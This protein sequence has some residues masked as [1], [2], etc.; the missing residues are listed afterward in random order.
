MGKFIF[1]F[2]IKKILFGLGIIF[3]F[4]FIFAVVS[5]AT[6]ESGFPPTSP[7]FEIKTSTLIL[8]VGDIK[9][10]REKIIKFVEE[11]GGL[12]VQSTI[13]QTENTSYGTFIL[14][15]PAEN[16]EETTVYFKELGERVTYERTESRDVR[17]EYSDLE[18]RLKNLEEEESELLKLMEREGTISEAL[19][20][21][22][23]LT[24]IRDEIEKIQEQ[25]QCLE[26]EAKMATVNLN[27]GISEKPLPEGW[28]QMD[29]LTNSLE[30]ISTFLR[31]LGYFVI[32][33]IVWAVIWVPLLLIV[34]YL[35]KRWRKPIKKI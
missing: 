17:E 35:K 19:E 34:L 18:P 21:Q 14:Q 27:L 2:M 8:L 30:D 3:A 16:F 11:K 9:E 29:F 26:R 7:C 33:V 32:E 22:M 23:D 10:T 28:R 13:T 12:V 20:A 5:F 31:M 4:C 15:V 1:K 24:R 25:K 6:E